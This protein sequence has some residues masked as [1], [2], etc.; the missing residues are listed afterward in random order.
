MQWVDSRPGLGER[1]GP[2]VS[3]VHRWTAVAAIAWAAWLGGAAPAAATSLSGEIGQFFDRMPFPPR[4][5][6]SRN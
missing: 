4:G 2:L 6:C 3:T 1:Q 5:T